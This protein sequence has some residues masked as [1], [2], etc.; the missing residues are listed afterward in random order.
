VTRLARAKARAVSARHPAHW[1]L[2]ADTVVEV[3]GLLLGKPADR[4]EAERMLARLAGREH[5]VLTGISLLGPRG[6]PCAEELVVTRVRFRALDGVAIAA[7]VATGEADDKAGAYAIQGKGA[8]LIECI[9]GS[10]TN[11]IGLPLGE[12]GRALAAVGLRGG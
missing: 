12:V 11:V 2:G 4:S 7:Y 1:V 8:G 5:Q 3:E 10:F 9:A 6:E